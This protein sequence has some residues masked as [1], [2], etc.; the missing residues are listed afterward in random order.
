[1]MVMVAVLL[2]KEQADSRREM[3]HACQRATELPAGAG[4]GMCVQVWNVQ[5]CNALVGGVYV[6]G[7]AI[8]HRGMCGVCMCC[9]SVRSSPHPIRLPRNGSTRKEAA[10]CGLPW[11]QP[12]AP[13]PHCSHLPGRAVALAGPN[14]SLQAVGATCWHLGASHQPP[15]SRALLMSGNWAGCKRSAWRSACPGPRFCLDPW[16]L[17]AR[18]PESQCPAQGGRGQ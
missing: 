18:I 14:M 13:G 2:L 4:A 5:C 7:C 3:G 15:S 10:T 6:T 11:V 1:M 16:P 8:V 12:G 17:G 9:H